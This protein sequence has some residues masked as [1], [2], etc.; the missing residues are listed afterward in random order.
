MATQ[1]VPL[2]DLLDRINDRKDEIIESANIKSK[3]N[4]YHKT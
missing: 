2:N 1:I 3:Y 4:G